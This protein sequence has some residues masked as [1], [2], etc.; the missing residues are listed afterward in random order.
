MRAHRTMVLLL[1]LGAFSAWMGCGGDDETGPTPTTTSTTTGAGGATST[2]STAVTT[3]TTVTSTS[4]GGG[5]SKLGLECQDDTDCGDGG[6]CILAGDTDEILLGGPA[7]GYCT[8]DCESDS[9]C[10]GGSCLANGS[11]S[12]CFLDCTIG[13]ELSFLDDELDPEN[14]RV[15]R[16]RA[17]RR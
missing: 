1:S 14:A 2:S 7:G 4:S 17:A 5:A 15:A 12:E 11:T 13:P 10:D 16:T 3:G 8:K 9:D 6:R